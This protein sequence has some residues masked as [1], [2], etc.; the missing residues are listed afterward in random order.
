MFS[1]SYWECSNVLTRAY[2]CSVL[3]CEILIN[4]VTSNIQGEKA[5]MRKKKIT[6]RQLPAIIY[7]IQA[8]DIRTVG[9]DIVLVI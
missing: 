7:E 4:V 2:F 5:Y 3:P 8:H 6:P 1:F 9:R